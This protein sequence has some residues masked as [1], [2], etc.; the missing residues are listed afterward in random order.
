MINHSEIDRDGTLLTKDSGQHGSRQPNRRRFLGTGFAAATLFHRALKAEDSAAVG[1]DSTKEDS[2]RT[3][4]V[5][6]TLDLEMSQNYPTW[7]QT[8]WNYEKGNLD[9][10]TKEYAVEA[11]R[12]VKA[13]GGR[14]HFFALG[15][16]MEQENV[17]WLLELIREGHPVGNHTYD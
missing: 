9:A 13:K 3:A 8:H 15:Q 1:T 14:I 10:A 12:R 16:T 4:Q 7:E 5:A 2:G 6:I 11:A 17:D